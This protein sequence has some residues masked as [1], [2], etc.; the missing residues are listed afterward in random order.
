[1]VGRKVYRHMDGQTSELP[2]AWSCSQCSDTSLH[3]PPLHPPLPPVLLV[4][5]SL[6]VLGHP[7]VCPARS[8]S[9]CCMWCSPAQLQVLWPPLQ[10]AAKKL[11]AGLGRAVGACTNCCQRL[12][13]WQ[14]PAQRGEACTADP[15]PNLAAPIT[16]SRQERKCFPR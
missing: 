11:G 15:L 5:G 2:G 12:R 9:C 1:M 10:E 13:G 8:L 14:G 6:G 7:V 4:Q 16:L 3:T